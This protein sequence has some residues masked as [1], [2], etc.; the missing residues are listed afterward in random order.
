MGTA[1][2]RSRVQVEKG[3]WPIG[4]DSA[5][6]PLLDIPGRV[7]W[8][9]NAVNKGGVWQTR[10]GFKTRSVFNLVTDGGR[11]NPQGFDW[12]IP[13]NDS[14][15]LVWAVSG[16]VWAAKLKTDGSFGPTQQ[17]ANVAFNVNAQQVVFCRALQTQTVLN[18][19]VVPT[20][21]R[22]VLIMQDGGSRACYWDGTNSGTLNPQ[23][24]V[25]VNAGGN[26]LFNAGYNE[27]R[28]GLWMAW[29]GNRLFVS[30]GSQVYA[31]DIGDPLHFTEELT[32]T[33]V[34]SINLPTT[35]T[36]MIDRGT[37]GNVAIHLDVPAPLL[38]SPTNGRLTCRY[39]RPCQFQQMVL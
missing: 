17:L 33:S 37:S 27:T 35:V 25:T 24:S 21:A 8:A 1:N 14:A 5:S 29:S 28:I 15:W 20:V 9:E 16:Y 39:Q 34:P 31:S 19:V 23:K 2:P 38:K 32:L 12:F 18:G 22:N 11:V 6:N 13:T 7:R 36:G 4:V 26:T 3:N 30:N 10:P